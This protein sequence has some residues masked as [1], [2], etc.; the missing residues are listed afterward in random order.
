M[1][2]APTCAGAWVGLRMPGSPMNEPSTSPARNRSG[3]SSNA[4]CANLAEIFSRACR[5]RGSPD[6]YRVRTEIDHH[7]KGKVMKFI[8]L[9]YLDES[10]WH[11]M[12]E[13]ERKSFM[14]Q[15]FA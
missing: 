15:C 13:S 1:R 11:A 7:R 4:G 10:R 14:E 8:C 5:F 12:S 9:G 6:D 3:D 2:H